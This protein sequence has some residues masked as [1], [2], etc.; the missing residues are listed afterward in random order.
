M[1]DQMGGG[2]SLTTGTP[3]RKGR[4][5]PAVARTHWMSAVIRVLEDR[6]EGDIDDDGEVL[7]PVASLPPVR[8]KLRDCL[9]RVFAFCH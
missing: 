6:V 1:H 5:S 8:G 9:R 2:K 4:A 7:G 3:A